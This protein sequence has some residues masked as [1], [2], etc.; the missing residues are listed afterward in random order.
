MSS[1]ADMLGKK[2]K[3]SELSEKVKECFNN[4]YD[5]LYD[6]IDKKDKSLRPNIIFLV[7]LDNV[8]IERPLQ[9]K[10]V[11]EVREKLFTIFG[12]R[13]LSPYDSNYKGSYL[14]DFNKDIAYHNG[15]VWPWLL[16]QFIKAYVKIKRHAPVFRESAFKNYIQPMLGIFNENWDGSINEI[17]DGDP[18]YTP[19]GCMTQAWSVAEILRCWVEDIENIKP[20]YEEA[21]ISP[22]ISV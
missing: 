7:S 22:E 6:V 10:I 5:D 9:E 17:F 2:E 4:Q 20:K 16:G 12:L 14:G 21:F 11:N 13:T 3:F 1:L 15:T 19:R 18:I 8:M